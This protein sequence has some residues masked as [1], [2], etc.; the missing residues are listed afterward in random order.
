MKTEIFKSYLEFLRRE[1]KTVNGVSPEFAEKHPD[2]EKQNATNKGCWDCSRC[3]G[4]SS[5]KGKHRE[6]NKEFKELT[7]PKVADLD[8]AVYAAASQPES[9][10]MADWHTCDNTHCRA[11]WI[12]TLAGKEG[13]ELESFHN[14]ELAA[15]LIYE[16]ST[17]R[18]ISPTK[19]YETNEQALADMKELAE[20]SSAEE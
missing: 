3:S 20:K 14:T 6:L 15:M 19:F 7:I 1:D 4:C 12:V 9:L 11:G 18:K 16:A 10:E 17:G 2:Y 8:K 13:K 5:A